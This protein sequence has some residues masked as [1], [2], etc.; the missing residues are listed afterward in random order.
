MI[1]RLKM[2]NDIKEALDYIESKRV[3]RTFE[4][5]Q[6]IVTKYGF[7]VKQKNM[8]H[9]AGTNGKGSTVNFIKEIL[10]KHGYTVGT[11]TSPYM[12]VHNDRICV[13]GK[14]IS[15]DKLLKIINE[16]EDIIKK[17]NLFYMQKKTRF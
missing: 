11:F 4:Q 16:L 6:E 14:M 15:D 10:M 1:G 7:N 13:N 9:I 8:I 3:K 12:I 17:E 2:F 5:F